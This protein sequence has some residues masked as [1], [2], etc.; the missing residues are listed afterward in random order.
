MSY[1][2]EVFVNV[3]DACY[4]IERTWH[5]INWCSYNPNL[6][7]TY[8]PNPHPSANSLAAANFV[9]PV[10]SA[11]QLPVGTPA[12]WQSTVVKI[13]P[14]DPVATNYCTFWS[15]N[16]NGYEY[17]QIIKVIDLQDPEI[18]CPA[19]PVEF[20]DY[21]A[22]DPLLWNEM[23]WWDVALE[24]HD[25]CEA[26]SDLTIDATDL[27]SGAE[28]NVAYQLFLDLN[29]DGVME[30]VINSSQV[31]T[32]NQVL[33]GNALTPNQ[34]GGTPRAFDERAVPFNQKYRFALQTTTASPNPSQ[35]GVKT[36]AVRWNTIQQPGT[37]V[38][39]ELPYG[40]HKI[41]WF[42]SDN[43]GNDA[44][45]EYVFTVKDCKKP[46]VVCFNGLSTN[47]MQ[48]G[49]ATLWASDFLLYGEDNCTPADQLNFAVRRSGA[50]TG[51]PLDGAGNPVTSVQFT[52]DD[53]G[54][55]F[56]E[57]WAMDAAGNVD[58]CETYVLIQDNMNN[59]DPSVQTASVAGVL[60]TEAA[61][62][63]EDV[64]VQLHGSHPAVPP[65]SMFDMSDNDGAYLFSNAIP[66]PAN[67]T[68]TPSKD[69]NPLNG[70]STFDLVKVA[71]HILGL[72]LLTTPYK[73][74]AADANHSGSI[75]TFDIVELRKLILGI[76][77][78]LPNNT[79]WRFVKADYQFPN[80]SNPFVPMFP[81]SISVAD[82]TGDHLNDDFVGIKVGDVNDS[83]IPNGLT[84]P[85]D[86]SAGTFIL[87]LED[88]TVAAG[89]EISVTF[90][91]AE[92]VQGYQFTLNTPGLEVLDIASATPD[93]TA[94]NFAVFT[95]DHALTTSFNAESATEVAVTVR[96]RATAAGQ[97]SELLGVS[98]RITKAEAYAP[99]GDKLDVALRFSR[100]TIAGVG[101]ELYQNQPNPFVSKTRI[102][103]H[104][105]EAGEATLS[106][107]DE[108]GRLLYTT[109]GDFAK[110]YNTVTLD[111]KVLTTGLLYYRLDCGAQS[112]TRKMVQSK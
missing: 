83:A 30:T 102:G 103:F 34:T 99:N 28:V 66:I 106:V 44:V 94:D 73:M 12:M 27:C 84:A 90:T 31:Q 88:R 104:L 14:S 98:S 57:L 13:D 8:V 45:C 1:T 55:Q 39:P 70:V 81:E 108:T 80:P 17:K 72:E 68:V 78:E 20:C 40:T 63:V 96:F 23:Y 29:G 5:V 47:I 25:L 53:L 50:G 79:S 109:T 60:E 89:E 74:I 33:F 10:V 107:F 36:A 3:P 6:P 19:S 24:Q 48:T 21:S 61:L 7:F 65:I 64:H 35:G 111:R 46:T 101:F 2:D 42:V 77:S 110:G 67:Y 93:M 37:F 56:V 58:F 59:C 51:F 22:N 95:A 49:M 75:T 91:G 16:A 62:G 26:P 43:C 71:R 18:D 11:C 87:D 52:C 76:Y 82:V 86:R 41:K 54:T 69:D 15:V 85:E 9:G 32:P 38:V 92:K 97:L 105:P 112:A 100:T 4:K